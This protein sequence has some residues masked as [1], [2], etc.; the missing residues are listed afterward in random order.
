M[1][2]LLQI[3]YGN[4]LMQRNRSC[5][6]F[7]LR[8]TKATEIGC[9]SSCSLKTISLLQPGCIFPTFESVLVQYFASVRQLQSG[10]GLSILSASYVAAF[11][12]GT[13]LTHYRKLE[14]PHV[15][16]DSRDWFYCMRTVKAAVLRNP[17]LTPVR[18]LI[19]TSN[20][21]F[22]PCLELSHKTI[23]MAV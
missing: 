2:Q 7:E 4:S 22:R 20:N 9:N 1:I 13:Y 16:S 3:H 21:G 5:S 10:T 17:V 14:S 15:V 12:L 8:T 6:A 23:S 11:Q 18:G 19:V